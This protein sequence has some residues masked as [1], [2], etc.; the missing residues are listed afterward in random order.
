MVRVRCYVNQGNLNR[1]WLLDGIKKLLIIV[2]VVIMV[3]S[4]VRKHSYLLM[5]MG[6]CMNEMTMPGICFK[7]EK[8]E[9][10]GAKT[11]SQG[12]FRDGVGTNRILPIIYI[13]R[14]I[15]LP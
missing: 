11:S 1:D 7:T 8:R 3:F 6:L 14:T 12:I 13:L 10:E 2:L 9:R 15:L 5:H 4:Y